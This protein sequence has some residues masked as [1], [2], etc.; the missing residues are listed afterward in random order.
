MRSRKRALDPRS[1]EPAHATRPAR[2]IVGSPPRS[3][4]VFASEDAVSD[5]HLP[6]HLAMKT[7]AALRHARR[8]LAA[9]PALEHY[10]GQEVIES[11][12]LLAFVL[13]RR[14]DPSEVLSARDL[15]R[16]ERAI[17]R[18][19]AGEPVAMI[20]GW[21]EFR[22]LRIGVRPSVFVPRE[23]S[24]FLAEQAVRRLRARRSP[25]AV[26]VATGVGPVALAIAHEVP[27]ARVF[28][29]DIAAPS[30]RTARA[31]ARALGLEVRFIVGDGLSRLPRTIRG[32][33]DVITLHPP[34]VPVGDVSEL[35]EEFLRFEPEHTLS[36]GSVDGLGL[37]RSTAVSSMTWLRRDGWLAVE[38][39]PDMSRRVAKVLRE[40]GLRAVA[41]TS[42]DPRAG[43]RVILGRR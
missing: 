31:N 37:A 11:H 35:P 18:R 7:T 14:P 24:E 8:A 23:S 20:R 13:D 1:S 17:E 29:T 5:A 27:H 43:T 36:D 32:S 4:L 9:S 25:I 19:L 15:H 38:V 26:D 33:V 3:A 12:E 30:I 42:S 22:G 10:A 39:S 21:E 16:F 6:D 28:A 34:Y 40:A 41:V 2:S